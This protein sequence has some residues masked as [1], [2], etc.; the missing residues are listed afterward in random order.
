MLSG[1]FVYF[2]CC[3]FCW[4]FG[5]LVVGLCFVTLLIACYL[6]GWFCFAFDGIHH[7]SLCLFARLPLVLRC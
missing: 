2:A 4:L 3:V 7:V 6:V 5:G 1:W